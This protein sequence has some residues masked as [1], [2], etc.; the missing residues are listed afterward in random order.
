MAHNVAELW[1]LSVGTKGGGSPLAVDSKLEARRLGEGT[2]NVLATV[3]RMLGRAWIGLGVLLV[4]VLLALGW[5][6]NGFGEVLTMLNPLYFRNLI[7]V[8]MILGPGLALMYLAAGVRRRSRGAVLKGI[9]CLAITVLLFTGALLTVKHM[10]ASGGPDTLRTIGERLE[11]QYYGTL[12]AWVARGGQI[13]EVQG[14]VVP[15]CSKLVMWTATAGEKISFTT[16]DRREYDFRVDVCV[17]TTVH[18]VHAQPQLQDPRIV[19]TLCRESKLP[20]YVELCR[21]SGLR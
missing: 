13:D 1:Q 5:R 16:T 11:E 3:L 7:A 20:L 18:R 12:D 9:A 10:R 6:R 21:R 17:K 19:Q 4:I 15:T 14:T 2:M 8:G